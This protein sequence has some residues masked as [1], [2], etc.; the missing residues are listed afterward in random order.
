VIA[1]GIVVSAAL[2]VWCTLFLI[3]NNRVVPANEVSMYKAHMDV[4][5]RGGSS[6][7]VEGER[8]VLE[9]ILQQ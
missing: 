7:V 3:K 4:K 8:A 6:Y 9:R 2:V 1:A 5:E